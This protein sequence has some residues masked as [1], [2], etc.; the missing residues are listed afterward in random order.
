MLTY[1]AMVF[2]C[3]KHKD[4][5]RK[6]TGEPYSAHLAEVAGIVAAVTQD[7][8]S[9]ATAWL[10][11][12]VE[13]QG[14]TVYELERRFGRD[15]AMG[16][17]NL[18]DMEEGNRAERKAKSCA[19]LAAASAW[20]QTVKCADLISNTKSIVLHDAKFAKTYLLEKQQLLKAITKA[21]QR[22]WSIAVELAYS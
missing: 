10:H 19:R 3:D 22:L 1:E 18:S 12:I 16:V 2:A 14:V 4:Q 17:Q 6:Y 13:D 9:I 7:E 15:V 11:D 8:V 20:V 21:D 5:K